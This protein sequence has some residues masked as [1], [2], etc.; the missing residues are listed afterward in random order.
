MTDKKV[1]APVP[2]AVIGAGNFARRQHLPNLARIPECRLRAVCDLD[3]ALAERMRERWGAEYAAADYRRVLDDREVEAVVIAVRDDMQAPITIAALDAGKHVY[4]EKPLAETPQ[5]CASVVEAQRRGGRRVAVGFNRRFAPIYR[6]ARE[7]IAADGG[8]FNVHMRMADDAWRWATGY[9]PGYLIRHDVCHL[10]DL[11]RW[12]SGSAVVSVYCTSSRPDDDS[13]VLR[14]ASGCVASITQSAHG[15]M[16]MPKER[17]EIISRRGGITAEDFVELRSYGYPGVPA[18]TTFAGHSHP[19]QEFMHTHLYRH[20]GAQGMYALRRMTWELRQRVESGVGAD[21]PDAA[22]VRRYVEN[23][24]P[25]FMRDQ[26]WL[27]A[28]RAFVVS[29]AT[30]EPTDHAGAEDALI[31]AQVADACVRSRDT[32]AVVRL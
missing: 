7:I 20:L 13:M 21:E 16:D 9:P 22:E 24:L 2:V 8:P 18:V 27:A 5:A 28:L 12:L 6:R 29:L 17:T 4:V 11:L 14:L 15:T 26:G 19:D 23:T 10:F 1:A 3:A 25:N 31:A 30:G 32:G